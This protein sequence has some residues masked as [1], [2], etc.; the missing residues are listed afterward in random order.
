MFKLTE[1]VPSSKTGIFLHPD[2]IFLHTWGGVRWG[3]A[4][5]VH[6]YL[7]SCH[8]TQTRHT[9]LLHIL[10]HWHKHVLLRYCSFSCACTDTSQTTLLHVFLHLHKRVI[11]CYCTF[12]CCCA[13]ETIA[14]VLGVCKAGWVKKAQCLSTQVAL[15]LGGN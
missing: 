11:L 6:A 12:P 1:F 10:L 3:G 14:K 9:M 8:A 13:G 7:T 5:K 2:M 4:I 15:T